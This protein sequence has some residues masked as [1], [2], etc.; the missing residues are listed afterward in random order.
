M[1][2]DQNQMGWD[3]WPSPGTHMALHLHQDAL[4]DEEKCEL[5]PHIS[6]IMLPYSAHYALML[7]IILYSAHC[8]VFCTL[9]SHISPIMLDV[10]DFLMMS[11]TLIRLCDDVSDFV[12]MSPTFWWCLR[13]FDDVSDFLM[14]SP[15]FWWCLR[16]FDDVSHISHNMLP[17]FAQYAPIFLTICSHISHNMLSYFAHSALILPRRLL[18]EGW[19]SLKLADKALKL[20]LENVKKAEKGFEASKTRYNSHSCLKYALLV[21][22]LQGNW[23]HLGVSKPSWDDC[24]CHVRGASLPW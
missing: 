12:M 6:H 23:Y 11:P 2:Q 4:Q 7:H 21:G 14:M 5:C 17:Y 9:C 19:K 1:G 20:H 3:V 8:Y 24:W 22:T 13:L 18:L 10:C 16:L 15:T